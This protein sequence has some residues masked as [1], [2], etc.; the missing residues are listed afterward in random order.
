VRYTMRKG[1]NLPK[2]KLLCITPG[3]KRA[4]KC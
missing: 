1:N 4:K 2:S 3:T